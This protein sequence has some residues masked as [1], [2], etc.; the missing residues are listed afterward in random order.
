VRR[1]TCDEWIIPENTEQKNR[2]HILHVKK[3]NSNNTQKK[4]DV[5]GPRS[6][7][8]RVQNK[9]RV[10]GRPGEKMEKGKKLL[11]RAQQERVTRGK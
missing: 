4:P 9:L 11:K 3:R 1:T 10:M 6:G 7:K 2:V 5:F 8:G